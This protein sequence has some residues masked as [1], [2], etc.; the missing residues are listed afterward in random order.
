MYDEVDNDLDDD[1]DDDDD[2]SDENYKQT[3][4]LWKR[5]GKQLDEGITA[6]KVVERQACILFADQML[7]DV[8][9]D[10]HLG[11]LVALHSGFDRLAWAGA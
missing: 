2:D 4:E 8:I 11:G 5:M 10:H 1:S 7:A 9:P 3:Y 6:N